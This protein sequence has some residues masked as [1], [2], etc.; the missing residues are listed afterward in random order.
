MVLVAACSASPNPPPSAEEP[1]VEGNAIEHGYAVSI[2]KCLT[3]IGWE[4]QVDPQGG[5]GVVSEMPEEQ[6]PLYEA[7]Y[8]E[9]LKELGLNDFTVTEETASVSYDNNTRVIECLAAEGFPVEEAPSRSSFINKTLE[10]PD[11]MI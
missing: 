4:V 8:Q 1:T 2:A 9:C 5:W 11:S 7:D 6:R 10:D 3:D